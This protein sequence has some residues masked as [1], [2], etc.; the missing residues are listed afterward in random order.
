MVPRQF[1]RSY[2][3]ILDTID[4]NEDYDPRQDYRFELDTKSLTPEEQRAKAGE[5]PIEYVPEADDEA[6]YAET[7]MEW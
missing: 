7:K 1:L 6:G 3:S 4:Q 2:V 5:K